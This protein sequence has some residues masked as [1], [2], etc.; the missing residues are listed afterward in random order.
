MLSGRVQP[1]PINGRLAYPGALQPQPVQQ[2][3]G[4][5]VPAGD[6]VR[7]KLGPRRVHRPSG[8]VA[9]RVRV[10]GVQA[11]LTGTQLSRCNAAAEGCQDQQAFHH[12]GV[13]VLISI[14]SMILV[15]DPYFNE[16]GY[17]PSR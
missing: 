2:W 16:P 5:P 6:M 12:D 15:S 9:F 1:C 11:Y 8:R 13:Q 3:Q 17:E 7:A 4:V 14:Q 10:S